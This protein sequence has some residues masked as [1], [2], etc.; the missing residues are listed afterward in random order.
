MSSDPMLDIL[1][2]TTTPKHHSE[3]YIKDGT[4]IFLMSEYW[5]SHTDFDI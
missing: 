5:L 3:Y 2:N 4:I 1:Q